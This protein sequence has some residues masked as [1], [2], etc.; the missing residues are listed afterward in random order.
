M[1]MLSLSIGKISPAI[2]IDTNGPSQ[3]QNSHKRA[4]QTRNELQSEKAI[5]DQGTGLSKSNFKGEIAFGCKHPHSRHHTCTNR[6][7]GLQ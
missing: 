3:A 2:Q 6:V 1:K 4:G 7:C 5:V